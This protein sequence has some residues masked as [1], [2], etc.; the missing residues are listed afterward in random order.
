MS[1]PATRRCPVPEASED[2]ARIDLA[3]AS[4]FERAHV[5]YG[6]LRE[7]GAI[8]RARFHLPDPPPDAP[9]DEH[10]PVRD[11]L[12]E[13]FWLVT[14]YD[15]A[16]KVLQDDA[17]IAVDAAFEAEDDDEQ[18]F[19]RSL[20]TLD[21]PD[22]TRL[23]KLV[24]P[25]F[26]GSALQ[27][28]EPRIR[29]IADDLLDRADAAAAG[30][31]ER[32]PDRTLELVEAYAYPLPVTV[33]SDMLGVPE[34]ER[35][36]VR[37]WTEDL[38]QGRVREVSR[39]RREQ[40]RFADWLRE[41]VAAKRS[42]PADDLVSFLVAA[43]DDG[44]RLTEDE[45]LSMVFLLFV[46]G[47]VTTVNLVANAVA[48][49]L[50]WPD[51]LALVR[52]EPALVKNVVE[53]TLRFWGPVENTVQRVVRSPVEIGGLTL[54][55]GERITACLAAADRDPAR[56]A[57]PERFDVT[58]AD[59][60][61]NLAFGRGIHTCLGAPL[62]RMEGCVALTALLERYPDLRPAVP[63]DELAWKATFLRGFEEVPVRV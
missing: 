1:R 24:Q 39:R 26:C 44:D 38:L 13:G 34:E 47:H 8:G 2:E 54:G 33:I 28:L 4:F 49:L 41:L 7:R 15:E 16:V 31:G 45:L 32:A 18:L 6:E 57:E 63:M 3:D 9:A 51:Q 14:D 55:P 53:E 43:E 60:K 29:R 19:T 25:W 22:H 10:D 48:A 56:F 30:R 5:L 11:R 23:R 46:A 37:Q 36:K 50:R 40:R 20:L 42:A 21:P 62:A 35:G 52:R 27:A 61:R 12:A 17:R 59:A 58:R